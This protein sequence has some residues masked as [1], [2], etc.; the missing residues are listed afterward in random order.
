MAQHSAAFKKCAARYVQTG[1]QYDADNAAI[2]PH[3]AQ[4]SQQYAKSACSST[5]GARR[6][7]TMSPSTAA[8]RSAHN[9]SCL[10]ARRSVITSSH[11]SPQPL[12]PHPHTFLQQLNAGSVP[13]PTTTQHMPLRRTKPRIMPQGY[14]ICRKYSKP[15]AQTL[16]FVSM[17][18]FVPLQMQNVTFEFV[19]CPIEI[20]HSIGGRITACGLNRIPFGHQTRCLHSWPK[21]AKPLLILDGRR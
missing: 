6:I 15:S 13:I 5:V 3:F 10:V 8:G 12:H 9:S 20:Q 2:M 21:S 7:C 14:S 1:F 19:F 16:I 11:C 18:P 17:V 4:Q